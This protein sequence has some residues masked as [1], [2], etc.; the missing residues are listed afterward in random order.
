VI[1]SFLYNRYN[2]LPTLIP[3]KTFIT[4]SGQRLVLAVY[5]T[6]GDEIPDHI[7]HLY[8][9]RS[10]KAFSDDMNY[11]TRYYEPIDLFRLKEIVMNREKPKMTD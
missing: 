4:V 3:M 6:L 5:H 2:L 7:R 1:K 10:L 8:Q 11:F 9:P